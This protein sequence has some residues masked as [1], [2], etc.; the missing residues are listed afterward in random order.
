[1]A[2][3]RN[4]GTQWGDK[5]EQA[6]AMFNTPVE[7][8]KQWKRVAGNI[9]FGKRLPNLSWCHHQAVAY[10]E[11]AK[12]RMTAHEAANKKNRTVLQANVANAMEAGP[13]ALATRAAT[14]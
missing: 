12:C 14:K 10:C 3:L 1:M 8:L 5:Y 6:V 4:N 11:P 9:E 7:T 13:P 2:A